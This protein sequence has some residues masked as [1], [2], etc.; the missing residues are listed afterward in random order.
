VTSDQQV[1]YKAG[2]GLM[3]EVSAIFNEGVA[4]ST[5]VAGMI[6]SESQIG[7]GYLGVEF[8]IIFATD[9]KLEIQELT[10]TTG[11][12]A[13]ENATV[14]IDGTPYTVPLTN[15]SINQN[16]FEISESLTSQVAGYNF[17]SN[18]AVV[19]CLALLPELGGGAFTFSSGTAVAAFVEIANGELPAEIFV[20]KS[21]WN[22]NPNIDINPQLGNVYKTQ[23]QYLGFG[24][25]FYSIE[26]PDTGEY[27][28]VHIYKYANTSVKPSV[29]NPIFRV[30]WGA[31]NVG[32]T[33]NVTVQ[34]GSAA[35]FIEGKYV[36]HGKSNGACKIQ[37]IPNGSIRNIL[38]VRNRLTF[39]SLPNRAG[40]FLK[41][42]SIATE[43]T[44]ITTFYVYKTPVTS[45]SFTWT[46]ENQSK[47]LSEIATDNTIITGGNVVACYQTKGDLL[48]DLE[49]V[50]NELRPMEYISIAAFIPSGVAS[51]VSASV[52]LVGD[53]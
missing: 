47:K 4:D 25:T 7:F 19:N 6:S 42:L 44:K 34:G 21:D 38:A 2:Q 46:Y 8:G 26:N 20:K 10:I 40:I 24:N 22:V 16:A 45:G 35:L 32:N 31:R 51:D 48:V 3:S 1:S 36:I 30:G 23:F 37:T 28:L 43:S 9:G 11:A 29:P 53:L 41:D 39:N 49:R 27:E 50:I 13:A 14:T 5:Q 33:T 18:L 15:T 12:G 17:T 52:T